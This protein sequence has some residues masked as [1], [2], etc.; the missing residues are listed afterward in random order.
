[1]FNFCLANIILIT[2]QLFQLFCQNI[3]KLFLQI[4][5]QAFTNRN[6]GVFFLEPWEYILIEVCKCFWLNFIV[7]SVVTRGD[8]LD[9]PFLSGQLTVTLEVVNGSQVNKYE[10]YSKTRYDQDLRVLLSKV[11]STLFAIVVNEQLCLYAC[12]VRRDCLVFSK[13]VSNLRKGI[14]SISRLRC[15]S[16]TIKQGD[17]VGS[18]KFS[19]LIF[20]NHICIA[21]VLLRHAI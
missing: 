17:K 16:W 21:N 2:S 4:A 18:E 1:M 10:E 6:I 15:I 14:C 11:F 8:G 3:L 9:V 19:A 5:L 7:C 12:A 20:K 13:Y